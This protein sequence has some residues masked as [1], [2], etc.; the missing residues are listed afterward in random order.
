MKI[1]HFT[2]VY[3]GCPKRC[4]LL[5]PDYLLPV[6]KDLIEIHFDLNLLL[7]VLL[8]KYYRN[9]WRIL[10]NKN[11]SSTVLYQET[12]LSLHRRD[13]RPIE[14]EWI[15]MKILA[16][17]HNMSICAFFVMLLRLEIAGLLEMNYGY[18][19]VPPKPQKISLL[20][21]ITLYSIPVYS[22]HFHMKP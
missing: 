6:Y 22:T 21:S 16:N 1:K 12:G 4:T 2:S 19:V 9:R 18:G 3:Y 7:S 14:S 11:I 5:I 20:K 13:F 8:K 15:E 10:H 17:S